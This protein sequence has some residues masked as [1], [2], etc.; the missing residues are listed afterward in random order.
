MPFQHITPFYNVKHTILL[1]YN[2]NI[3]RYIEYNTAEF[4]I[5]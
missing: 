2:I 3:L 1:E 5:Y 4:E